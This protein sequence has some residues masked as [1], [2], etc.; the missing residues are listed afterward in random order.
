[1][2]ADGMSDERMPATAVSVESEARKQQPQEAAPASL[3]PC[4]AIA[5]QLDTVHS[6]SMKAKSVHLA[7]KQRAH[8]LATAALASLPR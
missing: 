5:V 7:H 4:D 8:L 2:D 3:S 6:L 1:M